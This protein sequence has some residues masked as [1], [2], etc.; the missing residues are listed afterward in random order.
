VSHSKAMR[1]S[2]AGLLSRLTLRTPL[3]W[4]ALPLL[5]AYT[6]EAFRFRSLHCQWH[7][8]AKTTA[9]DDESTKV[10]VKD[11][12]DAGDLKKA[13]IARLKLDAA[14][15]CVRLLREVEGG[16]AP[17]PL[18]SRRA[19]AE[20]GVLE[21][22]SVLVEVLPPPPPALPPALPYAL[23]RL[24]GSLVP[25]KVAFAL[26]ADADDLKDAVCAKLKLDAAPNCVR[27]LREVEGGGAPVPLESL[28]PLAEQGVLKGC[29]IVVEIVPLPLSSFDSDRVI[30]IGPDAHCSKS[31]LATLISPETA[32]GAT[33]VRALSALLEGRKRRQAP[34]SG[35]GS[36]GGAPQI[37]LPL[38]ETE[39]HAALLKILVG[40]TRAL[41]SG[42]FVGYNGS[43]CCTL[44]G[45][46]GNGKSAVLR[47]FA[48][49][50]SSAFPG[51]IALYVSGEGIATARSPFASAHLDGL[52]ATAAHSRGVN[53]LQHPHGIDAS[54]REAGL[55]VLVLLDE[56]DD[57]YNVGTRG[58]WGQSFPWSSWAPQTST[59]R[60]SSACACPLPPV[61]P[62]TRWHTCCQC[63]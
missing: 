5:A 11:G 58:T 43:S 47:A 49:I 15:H 57:L 50:A 51:V 46:R 33:R 20:Q 22:S 1:G 17:V 16:G 9:Y 63:F 3:S 14:P 59:L 6:P 44:V 60:A 23:V 56:V 30:V 35:G 7:V 42:T 37:S 4:A 29:S 39:A 53:L 34:G 38:F 27:L 41:A 2:L 40:H 10:L 13:V 18:D 24:R 31:E 54:L 55:R 26:G 28:K 25:T 48:S 32:A 8:L 12:A 45:P 36:S 21:G 61:P 62:R 19:L 52:I